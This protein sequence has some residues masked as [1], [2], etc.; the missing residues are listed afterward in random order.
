MNKLIA[1]FY[2]VLSLYGCDI[3]GS[4][5]VHR[6]QAGGPDTLYSSVP[7]QPGVS[8]FVC[9]RS[10]SGQCHYTVFPSDCAAATAT[11]ARDADCSAQPVKRFVIAEGESRQVAALERFRLCVSADDGTLGSDCELPR[12]IAAVRRN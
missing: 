11:G 5:F 1:L 10:E 12:P 9:L 6:T 3:G 8:R 4:T 7:T 2:F